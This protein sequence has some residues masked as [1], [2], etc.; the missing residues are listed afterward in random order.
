MDYF[1]MNQKDRSEDANPLFVMIDEETGDKHSRV[2]DKKGLVH[3]GEMEWL[4]KDISDEL[5]AWCHL[6]GEG[7]RLILKSDGE[8]PIRALKEAVGKYHG[9]IVMMEVSA[10]G[11]SQSNGKCERAVQVVAEFV[12]VLKEQLEQRCKIQVVRSDNITHWMVRWAAMMLSKYQVGSDGRTPYER[13]R[14][15]RCNMVVSPFGERVLYKQIRE[16]KE[17]KD[18]F[19]SEDLEGVWLGHNRGSNE[20]LIG[21]QHGIVRAFS[22]RRRDEGSR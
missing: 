6:G 21:T 10:R 9:G 8:W 19:E 22:F 4:V 20:V 5:K 15:R 18:N 7:R 16:S 17:R 14:V 13:R 11:E 3:N 12:R 1:Y 2:V